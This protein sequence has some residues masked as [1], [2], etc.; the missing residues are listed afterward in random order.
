MITRLTGMVNRVFDDEIWLQVGPIEY[1][2]LVAE[3][4]RRALQDLVGA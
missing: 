2:V 3:I 4:G 1:Q